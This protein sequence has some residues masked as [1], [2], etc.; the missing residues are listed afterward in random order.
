MTEAHIEDD[1]IGRVRNTRLSRSQSLIPIFEAVVNSLHAI[2]DAQRQGLIQVG[3][4]RTTQATMEDSILPPVFGYEV[5]DNGVGFTNANYK[6]FRTADSRLKLKRGGKGI[7]RFVWLKAFTNVSISSIYLEGGQTRKRSF[8]F[9]AQEDPIQNIQESSAEGEPRTTVTLTGVRPLYEGAL[10]ATATTLA[11]RLTR[12]L[13][14]FLMQPSCAEIQVVDRSAESFID[15]KKHFQDQLLI[16]YAH[17]ALKVKN[18]TF[19]LTFVYM[20]AGSDPS[21]R[22]VLCAD[23]REVLTYPLDKLIPDVKGRAIPSP[24]GQAAEIWVV[25]SGDYLNRSVSQER[26][27][28]M[29]ADNE[30][31]DADA[32]DLTQNEL[33]DGVANACGSV[34]AGFLRHVEQ[35][36]VRRIEEFAMNKEPEYRVLLKHAAEGIRMIP[37]DIPDSKLDIELH[38]LLHTVELQLKEEGKEFLND[39]V[40]SASADPQYVERYDKYVEKLLDYRQSELAKY[41]IHRRT[42]IELLNKSLSIKPD[43]KFSLE[44]QV[45]KILYPLR[46]TSDDLEFDQQNLWLIDEK[47]TYHYYLASDTELSKMKAIDSASRNRPD[48][49]IFDRPAAFAEGEF[50]FQSIVIIELKRPQRKDYS[51]EEKDPCEQVYAY[52]EDI[53]AGKVIGEDNQHLQVSEKIRFYC[54]ILADMTPQLKKLAKRN[55]FYETPDGLGYFKFSQ[56]YNAYVEIVSYRKMLEDA[57]RRNRVLFEKLALPG[58]TSD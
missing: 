9:V 34:L 12:H 22:L 38:K 19:D 11:D 24:D 3:I 57:K 55:E 44:D 2:E 4:V 5:V 51:G 14:I 10:P 43:G 13:L 45:H 37:A 26:T 7:G 32:L 21:H 25:V 50:P 16:S 52:I 56:N 40:D 31:A 58:Y 17:Q 35:E 20:H 29:F 41:V 46:A 53:L 30:S 15:V 27:G 28:F 23:G 54:Y 49:L 48:V 8:E 33:N 6:S 36:K 42:I 47:L 1:V 18:E 39:K